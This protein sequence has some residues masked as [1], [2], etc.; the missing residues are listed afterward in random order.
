MLHQGGLARPGFPYD[1]YTFSLLDLQGDVLDGLLLQGS[2]AM[3]D[4]GQ[5]FN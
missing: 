3:I 4:M 1:G 5:P 2:P